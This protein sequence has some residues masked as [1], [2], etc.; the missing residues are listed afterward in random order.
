MTDDI[1]IRERLAVIETK[2]ESV[3]RELNV[4]V[5]KMDDISSMIQRGQGATWFVKSAWH[6]ITAVS[7]SV[8]TYLTM[9]SGHVP[10]RH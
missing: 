10:G 2:M 5:G 8:A 7:A 3:E 4:V 1:L 9:L 6:V